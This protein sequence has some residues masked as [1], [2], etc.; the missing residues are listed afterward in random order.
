VAT[1]DLGVS[2]A[3]IAAENEMPAARTWATQH[4]Y[5]ME[6]DDDALRLRFWL[7]GPATVDGTVA[8]E[9]MVIGEF[10]EFRLLPP[11]W[12]FVDPRDGRDVGPAAYPLVPGNTVFHSNGVICA[13]WNRLA[14]KAHGGPHDAWDMTNWEQIR[15]GTVALHIPDMLARIAHETAIS[16]GRRAPLPAIS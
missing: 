9:Y 1:L 13:P 3:Y 5:P 15:E 11:A 7:T 6:Y 10:E 2:R 12:R 16:R 14:Y 8:E 4:G